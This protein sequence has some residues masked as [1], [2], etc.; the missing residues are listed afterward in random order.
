[1][2]RE[3]WEGTGVGFGGVVRQAG[4]IGRSDVCWCMCHSIQQVW[5]GL[6]GARLTSDAVST[7]DTLRVL[8]Y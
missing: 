6:A 8:L 3:T 1:M 5:L 4:A 7:S 2:E